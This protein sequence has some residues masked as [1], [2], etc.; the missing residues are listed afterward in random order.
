M[1]LN[2]PKRF[3]VCISS[4]L[5]A[6]TLHAAPSKA[7][8]YIDFIPIAPDITRVQASGS[9]DLNLLPTGSGNVVD[10]SSQATAPTSTNT[11]G[12]NFDS[13]R[14][15][16]TYT[17]TALTVSGTR[18]KITGLTDPFTGTGN[19]RWDSPPGA[20]GPTPSN[21][22]L[23][24]LRASGG[25]GGLGGQDFWLPDT[26]NSNDPISGFFDIRRSLDSIGLLNGG[27]TYSI[28]SEQIILRVVPGPLPLLGAAT[29][30]G[31]TRRLR[32]RIR[33]SHTSPSPMTGSAI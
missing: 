22:P 28:G 9:L 13:D 15:L 23:F 31:F 7:T 24:L 29:A 20:V 10:P 4:I 30:F 27:T 25:S 6:A 1:K 19:I 16:A 17:P 33:A 26:Y 14:I 11:A 2:L 21:S 3:T 32:K 8:L 12:I 5:A 18:W